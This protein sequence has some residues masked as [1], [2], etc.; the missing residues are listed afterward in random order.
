M[1]PHQGAGAGQALEDGYV[2]G[3]A[4][5]DYFKNQ[6]SAKPR[7]IADYLHLYQSVR[8][9]RAEKVQETSRQAGGLYELRSKELEGLNYEDCLPVVRDLLKDR[10]KWIWTEDIDQVYENALAEL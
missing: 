4:L 10:M 6:K 3:R 5:Q 9:P 2:L 1:C 7:S 8:Y